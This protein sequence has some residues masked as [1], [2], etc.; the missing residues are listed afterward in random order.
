MLLEAAMTL[1]LTAIRAVHLPPPVTAM[2]QEYATASASLQEDDPGWQC[3]LHGNKACANVP[4]GAPQ[5]WQ[6]ECYLLILGTAAGVGYLPIYL[7][8][9][10]WNGCIDLGALL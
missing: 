7:P 1:A 5:V 9:E 3:N 8:Y 2:T 4:V 10:Y 6:D